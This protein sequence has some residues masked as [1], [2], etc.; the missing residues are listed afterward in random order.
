MYF[1]LIY[2]WWINL[3]YFDYINSILFILFEFGLIA[4]R[5]FV[6]P[7]WIWLEML[8]PLT[9]CIIHVG[10]LV[11]G[12]LFG[13]IGLSLRYYFLWSCVLLM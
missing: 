12:Y 3:G 6:W 2:C 8:F 5:L 4:Y 7:Y 9:M 1:G 11:I 10:L 13:L